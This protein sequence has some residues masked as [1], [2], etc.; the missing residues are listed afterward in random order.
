MRLVWTNASEVESVKAPNLVLSIRDTKDILDTMLTYTKVL[1]LT[2]ESI[3]RVG[4]AWII[5]TFVL[6]SSDLNSNLLFTANSFHLIPQKNFGG[7][8]LPGNKQRRS[9]S[10]I[11][12]ESS[13][14]KWYPNARLIWFFV[15]FSTFEVAIGK[16]QLSSKD[17][18]ENE[19]ENGSE[20]IL[21]LG[22][23][24]HDW[25]TE[26]STL[27]EIKFNDDAQ[28]TLEKAIFCEFHGPHR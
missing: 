26:P 17:T 4:I 24:K 1:M 6:C 20:H 9:N 18:Q 28:H 23:G 21:C 11:R 19:V 13:L 3:T 16:Q 8:K 12:N 14:C 5:N 10:S 7:N 15:L 22:S 27:V 25:A 2:W